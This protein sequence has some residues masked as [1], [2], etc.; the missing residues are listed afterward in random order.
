MGLDK[1]L[2]FS[3]KANF[4]IY[5]EGQPKDEKRNSILELKFTNFYKGTY[6]RML[7]SPWKEFEE[8]SMV[9]V[10]NIV[11][12][13]SVYNLI[14]MSILYDGIQLF[15]IYHHCIHHTMPKHIT[16]LV[17]IVKGVNDRPLMSEHGLFPSCGPAS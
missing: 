5:C 9:E 13:H 1:C 14:Y 15:I 16:I 8:K 11:L 12:S 10:F 17:T 7:K 3:N 4:V 6:I 2:P